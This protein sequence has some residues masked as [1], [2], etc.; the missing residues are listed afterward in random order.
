M[1]LGYRSNQSTIL[2]V[3]CRGHSIASERRASPSSKFDDSKSN[4][5]VALKHRKLVS[6]GIAACAIGALV[7]ACG[8]GGGDSIDVSSGIAIQNASVV[9]TRDGSIAQGMTLVVDGGKI[10]KISSIREVHTSG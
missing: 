2:A 5:E 9:N 3:A 1:P 10:Q 8:G 4:A 7:V 6:G